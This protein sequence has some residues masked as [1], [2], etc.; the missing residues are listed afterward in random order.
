MAKI[1]LTDVGKYTQTGSDFFTLKDDGDTARVRFLYD[2]PEGGDM[3]FFLV[4]E[5]EIDGKKRYVSCNAVDDEGR[6]HIEDC[7][8]CKAGNQ[9]KEKLFIQLYDE[10]AGVV[11]L[12]E[13]GKNFVPKIVS[14][15]NRYGSLIAQAFDIERRGKKGDTNT[16]YELYALNKDNKTINDFPQKQELEGGF[17][18]KASIQ[19]MYDMI[20]GVYKSQ[21]EDEP[22]TEVESRPRRDRETTTRPRHRQRRTED[23]F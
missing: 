22:Q 23:A 19:D 4:H 17:I 16:T 21:G 14:L 9:P 15:I 10:D 3:D 8:L 2:D 12:W 13:R 7:P 5:V 1:N 18:I 20:D 11:K 6:M